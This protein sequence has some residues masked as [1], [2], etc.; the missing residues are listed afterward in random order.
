MIAA[1]LWLKH[2]KPLTILRNRLALASGT[3]VA[4]MLAFQQS[5]ISKTDPEGL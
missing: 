3:I 2:N 5:V 4:L 1:G